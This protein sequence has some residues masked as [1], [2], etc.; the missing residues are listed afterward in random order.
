MRTKLIKIFNNKI[1]IFLL[2]GLLFS[3]V[4]VCAVTYF[5]S[6]QITYDNKISGLNSTNVQEA[7]DDFITSVFFLHLPE[8]QY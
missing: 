7:I 3:V 1:F 2:G 4:S 6:D 8:M 5:P